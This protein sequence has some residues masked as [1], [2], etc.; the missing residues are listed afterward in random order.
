MGSI[1]VQPVKAITAP[2]TMAATEPR[3][4]PNTCSSA[5]RAFMLPCARESIQATPRLT[6]RPTIASP[7]T[8]P[9]RTGT[10]SSRRATASTAI[11]TTSASIPSALTNAASTSARA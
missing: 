6:T 7:I 4:S 5:P 10:G 9:P 11:Q 3:M 2:A 1:G 8:S